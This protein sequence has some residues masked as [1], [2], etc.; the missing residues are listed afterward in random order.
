M[1][2]CCAVQPS[3]PKQPSARSRDLI[4][5]P[6]PQRVDCEDGQH[7]LN[8]L[9]FSH[10]QSRHESPIQFLL[11]RERTALWRCTLSTG[12]YNRG[13]QQPHL[14]GHVHALHVSRIVSCRGRRPRCGPSA[15]SRRPHHP[16]ARNRRRRACS[17]RRA[18]GCPGEAAAEGAGRSDAAA[19]FGARAAAGSFQA[20]AEENKELR[21]NKRQQDEAVGA[22]GADNARVQEL[23]SAAARRARRAG[24]RAREPLAARAAAS[25]ARGGACGARRRG[26]GGAARGVD[27]RGARG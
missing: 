6:C 9:R 26:R 13:K 8:G 27:A 20:V 3:N 12:V 7:D 1:H 18:S 17:L 5:L 11:G 2:L 14:V 4:L 19:A 10:V 23:A 25:R 21:D 15:R 24:A 22:A 16:G